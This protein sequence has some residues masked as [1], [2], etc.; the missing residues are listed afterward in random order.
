MRR[1]IVEFT[2]GTRTTHMFTSGDSKFRKKHK[3]YKTS[4]F[5]VCTV[6]LT[7]CYCADN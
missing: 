1:V 6:F 4:D 7:Y 5:T 2:N 3:K